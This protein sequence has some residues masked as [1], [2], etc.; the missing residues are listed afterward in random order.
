MTTTS[1]S[2]LLTLP[3]E[4]R[5]MIYEVLLIQDIVLVSHHFR[6][7][8]SKTGNLYVD[9]KICCEATS[10]F[11]TINC[12]DFCGTW[13]PRARAWFSQ[14]GGSNAA[15][16]RQIRAQCPRYQPHIIVAAGIGGNEGETIKLLAN[17]CPDLRSI[18]LRLYRVAS[19]SR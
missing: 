17:Y 4:I 19:V 7:V 15:C 5:N 14:I 16:I 3:G 8:R 12:F 10:I 13:I 6:N 9:C 2:S 11:Y 18:T 1:S